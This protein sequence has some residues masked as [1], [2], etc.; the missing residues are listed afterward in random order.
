[1]DGS[2]SRPSLQ[3][4]SHS[5]NL[6]HQFI[7]SKVFKLPHKVSSLLKDDPHLKLDSDT[8]F[9][10]PGLVFCDIADKNF[11]SQVVTRKDLALSHLQEEIIDEFIVRGQLQKQLENDKSK[12]SSKIAGEWPKITFLGTGASSLNSYRTTTGIL[13]QSEYMSSLWTPPEL[14]DILKSLK[15]VLISH[16]HHDHHE[17][18]FSV[19]LEYRKFNAD[20]LQVFAV[21]LFN[22]DLANFRKLYPLDS[23]LPNQQDLFQLHPLTAEKSIQPISVPHTSNSFAF[24]IN[25]PLADGTRYRLA[26]SG[27]TVPCVKFAEAGKHADLLIHE[28][29][30]PDD[31][32]N[33][34]ART[35]HSTLS[36]ALE[37]AEQMKPIFTILTHFSA[38]NSQHPPYNSFIARVAP[39][40]DL[41]QVSPDDFWRLPY[42]VPYYRYLNASDSKR[43][44]KYINALAEHR[45]DYLKSL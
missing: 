1:M 21:R 39:A 41:M 9:A 10:E 5:A 42:Y 34:A 44:S 19:A 25:L 12:N 17:G 33:T 28:A 3:K 2:S 43:K 14:K 27:D 32:E 26:Y 7:D 37:I 30:Y 18:L 40:F 4:S 20:P 31:L 36:G 6:L 15:A 29:T 45:F 24:V 8:V 13:I 16:T 11:I 38:R 35:K 22:E 23:V